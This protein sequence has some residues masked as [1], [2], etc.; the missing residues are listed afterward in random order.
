M[1][2]KRSIHGANC[3]SA[4]GRISTSSSI[5][6]TQ[7]APSSSATLVP[8][9]K[10]PEPPVLVSSRWLIEHPLG[11]VAGGG[12]DDLLGVVGAGVVDDDDR[13]RRRVHRRGAGQELLEI[14][15]SVERHDRDGDL[16]RSRIHPATLPCGAVAARRRSRRRGFVVVCRWAPRVRVAAVVG[17]L[18][19]GAGDERV[20]RRLERLERALLRGAEQVGRELGPRTGL[21]SGAFW[22]TTSMNSAMPRPSRPMSCRRRS[23]GTRSRNVRRRR[24]VWLNTAYGFSLARKS[25]TTL[26]MSVII[27][28]A[29][30]N[31]SLIEPP[32]M[33]RWST[34]VRAAASSISPAMR[35]RTARYLA[36]RWPV[37]G[38]ALNTT[39]TGGSAASNASTTRDAD[40]RDRGVLLLEVDAL[41]G[42]RIEH[43]RHGLVAEPGLAARCRAPGGGRRSGTGPRAPRARSGD[44][45]RRRPHRRPTARRTPG[46]TGCWR[47]SC[48]CRRAR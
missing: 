35:A 37:N 34:P 23:T 10:P 42:R 14:G 48:R 19:L 17:A 5:S 40:G 29:R 7:S 38:C 46:R 47:R 36:S 8:S 39:R 4:S 2:L 24:S 27:A 25:L 1:T 18:G 28:D 22:V 41:P 16:P 11:E 33:T 13:E 43:G 6:H 12:S 30:L 45:G 26:E 20:D 9:L 32:L 15:R 3:S 21:R 31:H 44:S